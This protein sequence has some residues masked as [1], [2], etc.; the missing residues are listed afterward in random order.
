MPASKKKSSPAFEES[1]D[2]L[3]LIIEQLER[4]DLTLDSALLHFE[5]GI[6]LMRA[7]D[8]HLKHAKGKLRELIKGENGEFITKILGENLESFTGG[9]QNDG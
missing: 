4:D 9:E 6:R 3:E 7:C 1:L 2:K 8:S 5:D